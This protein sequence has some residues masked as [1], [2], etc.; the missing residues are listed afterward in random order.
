MR[1]APYITIVQR[2][3]VKFTIL[4][5]TLQVVDAAVETLVQVI[6]VL[7]L[8]V[9]LDIGLAAF[10]DQVIWNSFADDKNFVSNTYVD[11]RVGIANYIGVFV[12]TSARQ[13]VYPQRNE[14]F[15]K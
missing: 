1:G 15:F 14:L 9:E 10:F 13:P 7:I 6:F 12:V 4:L 8:W 11:F 2:F 5:G 3:L